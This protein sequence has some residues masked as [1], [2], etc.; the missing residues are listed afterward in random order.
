MEKISFEEALEQL[1]KVVRQL[2]Q[3]D[4]PLEESIKLFEKGITLSRICQKKLDQAEAK[5]EVLTKQDDEVI[6]ES[7]AVEENS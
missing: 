3:G 4:V 2:E 6:K 7:F 1:E 5:I